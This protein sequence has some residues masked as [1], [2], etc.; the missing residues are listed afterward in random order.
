[1]YCPPEHVDAEMDQLIAI[2][3]KLMVQAVHPLIIA[4]RVHHAFTM[5]HPFQDGNGSV[6]RLLASLILIKYNYFPITV[7]REEA[8]EKYIKALEAADRGVPQQLVTYFGEIQR[9][10]IEE[11]LSIK[12][13]ASTNLAEVAGIF[14]EK[15]RQHKT[16]AKEAHIRLL[17]ERRMAIF[18]MC[19]R[20]LND[21]KRG[22]ESDF[23]DSVAFYIGSGKPDDP[24]KQHYHYRQ[25]VAYAS[26]HGYYF[27]RLLPRAYLIFGIDLKDGRK[28]ETGISIHHYGYD[29]TTIAIG[30]FLEYKGES[31][32]DVPD[33]VLPLDL[34][35]H[36]I[37]I[38]DDVGQKENNIKAYLEDILTAIMAH[39]ASEV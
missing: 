2:L 32:R 38:A 9:R 29:D 6:V 35:P 37:S 15:V 23:D 21:F 30:G 13:V 4:S 28:Y 7:L 25:I 11:A 14:K 1:M 22:L 39:I 12:E 5:I 19:N 16:A 27:N 36:V 8:K 10:N 3:H 18:D 17:A 31:M 33:T 20:Y 26:K 34:K 24:E